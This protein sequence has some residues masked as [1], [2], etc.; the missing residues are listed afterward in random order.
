MVSGR[1]WNKDR[2]RQQMRRQGVD[3]ISDQ[4]ARRVIPPAL[5][6]RGYGDVNAAARW[7]LENRQRLRDEGKHFVPVL[8]A[9]FGLS[10][11]EACAAIQECNL[12][13]AR[14]T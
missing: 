9:E 2:A 1:D 12:I 4:S 8:Q 13:A 10:T 11:K 5:K 14:A 6:H 3:D 7:L